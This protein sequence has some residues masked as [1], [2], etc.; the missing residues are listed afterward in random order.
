[1][2]EDLFSIVSHNPYP[3]PVV[4]EKNKL[5]GIVKTDSI[6]ESITPIE[7]GEEDV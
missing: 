1:M 5:L 7:G 4:D 6:F 3:V 2:I